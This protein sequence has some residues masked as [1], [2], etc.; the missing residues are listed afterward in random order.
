MRAALPDFA[1]PGAAVL[2]TLGTLHEGFEDASLFLELRDFL[3]LDLVVATRPLPEVGSTFSLST[4][5]AN[6]EVGQDAGRLEERGELD[7]VERGL[8]DLRGWDTAGGSWYIV[9]VGAIV[10]DNRC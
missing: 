2:E 5:R 7:C 10:R 9:K 8:E 1:G 6:K 4:S 3:L